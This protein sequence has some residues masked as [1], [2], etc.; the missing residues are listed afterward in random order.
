MQLLDHHRAPAAIENLSKA[1]I[2]THNGMPAVI[3][4]AEDCYGIMAEEWKY[5]IN[6]WFLKR[7][8]QIETIR[9]I[10]KETIPIKGSI[11]VGVY[12]NKNVFIDVYNEEDFKTVYFKHVIE[13]DG[14]PMWL[15]RWTPD[16][17]PEEDSPLTPVWV[18]LPKLPFHLHTWHYVKQILSPIGTPMA[19]D[20]ATKGKTRPSM[21]KVRIK[22][23]LTKPRLNHVFVVS[24]EID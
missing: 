22:I 5:T 3:F 14:Q 11:K 23:D 17:T 6:G 9:A 20:V 7:R 24:K 10:I 15:S 13:I 2:T 8:P 18:L 4:D 21:T 16:F 19:M 12:D 1:E